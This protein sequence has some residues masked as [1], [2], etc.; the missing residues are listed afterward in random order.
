[1]EKGLEQWK[2]P[3]KLRVHRNTFYEWE[4]DCKGPSRRSMERL[5]KLLKMGRET[6]ED[7]KKERKKG[8]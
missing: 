1:L 2:L 6:P 7:F 4:K 8:F 5:V 3:K